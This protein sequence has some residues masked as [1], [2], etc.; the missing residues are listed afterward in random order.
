MT[1]W[2]QLQEGGHLRDVLRGASAAL[3]LQ[4]VGA[5]A[6]FGFNVLL[7]RSLGPRGV[8][9]YYLA[10]TVVG[11][12]TVLGRLG[13][14]NAMLRYVA[15]G[16]AKGDWSQV[17]GV[18]RKGIYLAALSLTACVIGLLIAAPWIAVGLFKEPLLTEP[19]RI[20][21]L[22]TLPL[23]LS[24]LYGESLR[25]VRRIAL[26]TLVQRAGKPLVGAV[27]LCGLWWVGV[28]LTRV[29]LL[30]VLATAIV[31]ALAVAGWRNS[32][33]PARDLPGEFP[34]RLLLHTALPLLWVASM[35]LVMMWTDTV[36]LGMFCPS[37]EVGLYGVA[38]RAA[39]LTSFALIAINAI[40]APK[41]AVL[42]A[43]GE[44]APLAHLAR[45]TTVLMIV[46]TAPLLLLYLAW[47]GGVL[48]LFGPEFRQ[49]GEVLMI[50]ALGQFVNVST[51]S[52]GYL[53]MMSGHEKLMRNNIMFAGSL[54]LVLNFLL[55]PALGMVGA[56]LGT[57]LSTA[58]MN[59]VSTILVYRKLGFLT[60]P[61]WRRGFQ[62]GR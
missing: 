18:H 40:A 41:Y 38:A 19:L 36:V 22:A 27:L 54:N 24:N 37:A 11:I 7:A 33:G 29:A 4:V 12:G 59:I 45:R 52:V 25:G 35:N 30:Y 56:A 9:L 31:F 8:G 5:A 28:T 39:T 47:P 6:G 50:L 49:A 61:M 46:V 1:P 21:A 14:D 34:T 13:L 26:A 62:N 17:A 10:L 55:V 2:G 57:A 53:L 44:M 43:R 3:A 42:H 58:M 15:A 60:V 51:G 20:M 32:A 23:G 48:D 16:A